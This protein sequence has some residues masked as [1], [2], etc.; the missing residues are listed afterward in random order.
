MAFTDPT[1][2][3]TVGTE[4]RT[5]NDIN[6]KDPKL[7]FGR[8]RRA[9]IDSGVS[10]FFVTHRADKGKV[11][12]DEIKF[13]DNV[14]VVDD[15]NSRD[16]VTIVATYEAGDPSARARVLALLKAALAWTIQENYPEGFTLG[17]S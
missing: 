6:D 7:G 1:Q 5:Y 17:L 4:T 10:D 8:H 14:Q 2:T 15:T 3:I 12:R 13:V 11:A 9:E 16:Q